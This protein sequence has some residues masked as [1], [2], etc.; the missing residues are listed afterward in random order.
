MPENFSTKS[1][2]FDG[3]DMLVE[4]NRIAA[5]LRPVRL[6][7]YDDSYVGMELIL[8]SNFIQRFCKYAFRFSE[9]KLMNLNGNYY[10]ENKLNEY[11]ERFYKANFFH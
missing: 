6:L 3:D 5:G 7:N 11:V 1:T 4:S 8:H 10:L 9:K 2:T